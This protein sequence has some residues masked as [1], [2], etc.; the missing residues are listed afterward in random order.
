MNVRELEEDIELITL[1]S[2]ETFFDFLKRWYYPSDDHTRGYSTKGTYDIY[3]SR[4]QNIVH[5]VSKEHNYE[6]SDTFV[7]SALIEF[8]SSKLFD[9][10]LESDVNCLDAINE[11]GFYRRVVY[12]EKKEDKELTEREQD[13]INMV[14]EQFARDISDMTTKTKRYAPHKCRVNTKI[15]RMYGNMAHLGMKMT[16]LTNLIIMMAAIEC[17]KYLSTNNRERY[18]LIMRSFFESVYKLSE[19]IRGEFV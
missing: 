1:S 12:N 16:D 5:V 11:I 3:W 15:D 8:Y 18:V 4:V 10:V 19:S 2:E 17:D 6:Y 14:F 7:F 13:L 9:T